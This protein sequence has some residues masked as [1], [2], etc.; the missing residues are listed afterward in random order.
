MEEDKLA[1]N[2]RRFGEDQTM[3]ENAL[4]AINIAIVKQQTN[5]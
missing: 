4:S 1:E 3:A 2:A 5:F